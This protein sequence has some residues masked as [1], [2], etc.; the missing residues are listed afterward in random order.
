MG[1]KQRIRI[2]S[3]ISDS[4]LNYLHEHQGERDLFGY[5][6]ADYNEFVRSKAEEFWTAMV[7]NGSIDAVKSAKEESGRRQNVL[8]T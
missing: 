6:F 5:P 2:G 7:K 8:W 3:K 1:Q 4:L